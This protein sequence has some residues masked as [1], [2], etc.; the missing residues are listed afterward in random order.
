MRKLDL[1]KNRP[2]VLLLSCEGGSGAS[3]ASSSLAQ[4]LKKSG[5][6]AI[7]SYGQ[8]LDAAEASSVAVKFVENIRAGKTLLETFR[9]LSRDSAVK[10]GPEVHL[11]VELKHQFIHR[12]AS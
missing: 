3:D 2:I 4:E 8:K 12:L 9:L 11:K 6:T 5:A 10:A 1:H 7:W